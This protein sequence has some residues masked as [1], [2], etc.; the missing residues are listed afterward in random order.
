MSERFPQPG[1][2]VCVIADAEFYGAEGVLVAVG[3]FAHEVLLDQDVHIGPD[4][5]RFFTSDELEWLDAHFC[6]NCGGDDPE[7]CLYNGEKEH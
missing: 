3:P 4:E 5:V 7:T 6:A 1:D 2:R